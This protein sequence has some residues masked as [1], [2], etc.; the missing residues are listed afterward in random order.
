MTKKE[1]K[2]RVFGENNFI[3]TVQNKKN[4]ERFMAIATIAKTVCSDKN[5]FVALSIDDVND[6]THR[7]CTV[8]ADLKQ[9]GFTQDSTVKQG[10]KLLIDK[11][12]MMGYSILGGKLRVSFS[13]YD[14]WSDGEPFERPG[15]ISKE[16][17]DEIERLVDE[18]ID[19][20]TPE[21]LKDIIGD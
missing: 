21:Q 20:L 11:C 16:D 10:L 18:D 2:E 15:F 5:G 14:V 6:S 17:E 8:S 19:S 4:A 1:I 9:V 13:V 7:N 12:D 3:G